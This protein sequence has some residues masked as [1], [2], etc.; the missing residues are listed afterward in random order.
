MSL[1]LTSSMSIIS[2][3]FVSEILQCTHSFGKHLLLEFC[4]ESLLA[5]ILLL[6]LCL[7]GPCHLAKG[8]DTD[9]AGFSSLN[10]IKQ[11]RV[12]VISNDVQLNG[13]P[14]MH[15]HGLALM[16]RVCFHYPQCNFILTWKEWQVVKR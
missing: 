6:S 13:R 11:I 9:T 14:S 8:S 16:T 10:V 3:Q 4:V 5:N 12:T 15:T 1:K 7:F 2:Q